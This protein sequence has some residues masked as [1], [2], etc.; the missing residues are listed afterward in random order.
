MNFTNQTKDKA[1]FNKLSPE[2]ERIILGKGTE[3]PFS[4][5]YDNFSETGLYRCRHCGQ[6]L[7]VSDS[8]FDSGCGWPSFDNAIPGAVRETPDADGQRTEITCARCEGHLGHVFR[9]ENMTPKNTRH[10]VNSL[11][12]D[13]V[14]AGNSAKLETAVY[15][16][17][18][19][20]GVEYQF[21]RKPGVLSTTVGFT[22]GHTENPSYKEV[23]GGKTGHVE[24]ILVTYDA[25]Q[26]SY[27]ELTRLFFETHDPGQEDGQGP[28]IGEQYHS[29]LFYDNPE[30]KDTAEQLIEILRNKGFKVVTDLRPREAFW[31]AEDYH[32]DYYAK[33]NGMPYCHA[34]EKKF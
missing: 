22:G 6:A 18:C 19:F 11:S 2:E 16:S 14:A 8:K 26:V 5:K 17:G 12:M 32:Q 1:M 10:C 31:P 27:D 15:A 25:N 20:W 21:S 4:G 33:K 7:F 9:G 13:F 29:V 30:Q 34:Y 24:A 23:C 3:A 28:D